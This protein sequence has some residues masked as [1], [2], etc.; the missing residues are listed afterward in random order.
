[1]TGKDS[2]DFLGTFLGNPQRARVLRAFFVGEE[3]PYTLEEI[4]KKSRVPKAAGER[5]LRALQ[6]MGI[7]AR[8]APKGQAPR[9]SLDARSKYRGAL[10]QFVLAVAPIRHERIVTALRDAG[11]LSAVIMSGSLMGDASRPVDLLIVAENLH[12]SRLARIVRELEE[13]WGKEIRYA[14]FPTDEFRYRMTV[15]DRLLR[16]TLDFPHRVLLDTGI[17]GAR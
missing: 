1:M 6:K 14:A 7:V 10:A 17:L 3:R 15:Q 13:Q 12:E 2:G 5:E 9:W 11:K 4:A 16:D 8:S